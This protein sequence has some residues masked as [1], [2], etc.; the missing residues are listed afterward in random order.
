L[1][2][3][4]TCSCSAICIM[5]VV[6]VGGG[7]S[8]LATYLFLRKYCPDSVALDIAIYEAHNS[9]NRVDPESM[10]F[11]DLSTSATALVGGG[12]GLMPNGMRV[13]LALDE[14]IHKTA[15]HAGFVCERSVFKS[16]RG[17]RLLSSP[18]GDQ[19]GKPGFPP[20]KEEFCVSMAR[21]TLW[22]AL[23]DQVDPDV[24]VYKKIVSVQKAVAADERQASITLEGG[25]VIFADLVIGA[26]GVR[27]KVRA[28]MFDNDPASDAEY[29]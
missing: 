12:I 29:R 16:A 7:I 6:I 25:E 14:S 3:S 28:G 9:A 21:H 27:S 19:R 1:P 18:F 24:I 8:G 11:G 20:G 10:T 2:L 22:K 26:D 4:K 5:K 15:Q 17:W 13:L 23:K